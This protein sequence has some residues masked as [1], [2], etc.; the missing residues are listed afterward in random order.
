L[1]LIWIRIRLPKMMRIHANPM[2][3]G[4]QCKSTTTPVNGQKDTIP[5]L[6]HTLDDNAAENILEYFFLWNANKCFSV[7]SLIYSTVFVYLLFNCFHILYR[8]NIFNSS[9]GCHFVCLFESTL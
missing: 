7:I 6:Q 1:T 8:K 3:N 9:R 4:S 2:H 5:A